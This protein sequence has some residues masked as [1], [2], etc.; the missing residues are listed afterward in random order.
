M[1]N[2]GGRVV[3]QSLYFSMQSEIL[4]NDPDHVHIQKGHLSSTRQRRY[5]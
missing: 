1:N 4:K 3:D 2:K 5:R